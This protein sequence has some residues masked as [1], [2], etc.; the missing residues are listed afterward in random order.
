MKIC[1]FRAQDWPSSPIFR[2]QDWHLWLG[3][4]GQNDN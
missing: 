2:A 3:S 4:Y 1:I